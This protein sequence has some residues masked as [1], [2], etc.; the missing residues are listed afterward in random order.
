[1]KFVK[2]AYL[3]MCLLMASG[4]SIV[5]CDDNT[6]TFGIEVMPEA[7][8]PE[9]SQ[10]VRD[11]YIRS[12]K[13]D[14]LLANTSTCYLGRVTDPETHSTTTCNYLAQFYMIAGLKLPSK[15]CM[16]KENGKVVA[17]SVAMHL[18]IDS[19][20]GDSLNTIKIGVYELDKDKVLPEGVSYYSNINAE[21][22]V[23]K[24]PTAI[25][26][27]V[28]FSVVDLSKSDSLR[29]SSSYRYVYVKLPKSFGSE[30]LNKYYDHPEYFNN[31]YTFMH[32]VVPGFY[33]KTLSGNGTI[34]TISVTSLSVYYHY[35]KED[36]TYVGVQHVAATE[37]VL[38]NNE[39][40]N[41]NIDRL[42]SDESCA[43]LKTP[44]GIFTLAELPIDS[45]YENH[46]NDTVN[47]A[48]IVFKRLNNNVVTQY[49]F[50]PP[51]QILMIP[52]DEFEAFFKEHQVPD[53]KTTYVVSFS[54]EYNSYT[55]SNISNLVAYI[56]R[57]RDNGA[58]VA[59]SESQAS[60]KLKYQKWEA[61]NPNWNKV[62][63]V[64]VS[65]TVNSSSTITSV[66]HDFSLASTKLLGGKYT[67]IKISVVYSRFK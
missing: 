58:G 20:Y 10:S 60:R 23:S 32:N 48:R 30:I 11:V 40:E 46:D 61:A 19:Y 66:Y 34:V 33:F 6:G 24:K 5:S 56:K 4:L 37:E 57:Q 1:M 12:V 44:A 63:L 22:Y 45:I 27:T 47:S 39:F 31:S 3:W 65:T 53:G 16:Y 15:E 38:Q 43:Y 42:V 2:S 17:D 18:E 62:L 7:D 64:P 50:S 49:S 9:V 8:A 13:V 67:P 29:Y 26:K 28:T 35:T 36:S 59:P 55:F 41:R 51:S 52:V 54:S 25:N 14:S 21:Q